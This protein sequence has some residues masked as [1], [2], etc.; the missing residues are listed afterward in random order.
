M[1]LAGSV[2]ETGE[3][4]FMARG[5][6]RLKLEGRYVLFQPGVGVLV[7]S[8]HYEIEVDGDD[9]VALAV[10]VLP[11]DAQGMPSDTVASLLDECE[12]ETTGDRRFRV[13]IGP[14]QGCDAA[15][16]FVGDIP[17]A[18]RQFTNTPMT[19]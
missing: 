5:K 8:G 13:L 4:W 3:L 12:A 15:T 17:L 6:A 9:R 18:G 2:S 10:V 7:L 11:L 14:A 19:K 1:R 16:Q